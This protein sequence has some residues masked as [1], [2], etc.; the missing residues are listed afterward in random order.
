MKVDIQRNKL[1]VSKPR[2]WMQIFIPGYQSGYRQSVYCGKVINVS[3][4]VIYYNIKT[5][6]GS[7]GSLIISSD[8]KLIGI[9]I[10]L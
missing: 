3:N 9:I 10:R 5:K 7:S 2:K 6:K 4:D 8:G 1:N